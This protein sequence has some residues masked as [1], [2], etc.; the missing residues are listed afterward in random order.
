MN[1]SYSI[2]CA[3]AIMSGIARKRFC[4]LERLAIGVDEL[5]SKVEGESWFVFREEVDVVAVRFD[6]YL[7]GCC[8]E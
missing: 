7:R 8:I 4:S 1:I 3:M 5:E 2:V 6:G